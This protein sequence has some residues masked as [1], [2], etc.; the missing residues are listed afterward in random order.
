MR[1]ERERQVRLSAVILARTLAFV[2][3]FDLSPQGKVFFPDLVKGLVD[4]YK[5]QKFP[6]K[7]EDF[8]IAKAGII[9]E[10]GKIGGKVIQKFT[11]FD[12][13]LVVETRSNTT[14]SKEIIE[15]ML[16]WAAGKYGISYGPGSIKHNGYVSGISF[17]SDVPI[18]AVNPMLNFLAAKMSAALS[19][20]WQEPI[21]YETVGIGVG[22]DPGTRKF[23]IAQF[24]VTRREAAKFSENKYYSEA[25]LPTDLHLSLL[26]EYESGVRIAMEVEAENV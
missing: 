20:I 11:I 18:L 1:A 2:E 7:W 4:R 24:T 8:D 22:H 15:E 26:E 9:F 10:S 25:P 17:Y 12:T 21:H 5:F 3:V 23:P 19:D 14:D 16:S 6:T 13:L